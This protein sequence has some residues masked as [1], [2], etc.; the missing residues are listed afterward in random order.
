[1]KK[2]LEKLEG[3]TFVRELSSKEVAQIK[4]ALTHYSFSE[5]APTETTRTEKLLSM[6][7]DIEQLRSD[8]I[9]SIED[10]Q[11]E[12]EASVVEF[13]KERLRLDIEKLDANYDKYEKEMNKIEM[14]IKK[15]KDTEGTSAEEELHAVVSNNSDCSA[16]GECNDEENSIVAVSLGDFIKALKMQRA[17]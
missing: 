16:C 17:I 2:L 12:S 9:K 15:L 6:A 8:Y 11:K 13:T 5:E 14:E 7:K 3:S 1:M 10:I 4:Q